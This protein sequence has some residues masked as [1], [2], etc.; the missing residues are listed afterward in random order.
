[1]RVYEYKIVGG[2]PE[3]S[4]AAAEGWR[5]VPMRT[6]DNTAEHVLMERRTR[7]RRRKVSA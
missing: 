5:V 1:M 2:L 7:S 6:P 4:R 3:V